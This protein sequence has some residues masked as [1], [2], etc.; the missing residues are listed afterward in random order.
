MA[1]NTCITRL[2]KLSSCPSCGKKTVGASWRVNRSGGGGGGGGD[3]DSGGGGDDSPPRSYSPIVYEAEVDD[4]GD[5]SIYEE[6]DIEKM[7]KQHPGKIKAIRPGIGKDWDADFLGL[8]N[9]SLKAKPD[10]LKSVVK[11]RVYKEEGL[12]NLS[13][14]FARMV[15]CLTGIKQLDI[16]M[17]REF[18]TPEVIRAIVCL[19]ALEELDNGFSS[20]NDEEALMWADAFAKAPMTKLKKFEVC[21]YHDSEMTVKG[22]AATLNSLAGKVRDLTVD[23][24]KD[25]YAGNA[26]PAIAAL[27]KCLPPL[28]RLTVRISEKVASHA[29][30]PL[31]ASLPSCTALKFFDLRCYE[32]ELL[33]PQISMILSAI[34]ACTSLEELLLASTR[35]FSA[36]DFLRLLKI[37]LCHPKLHTFNSGMTFHA[38]DDSQYWWRAVKVARQ[39]AKKKGWKKMERIDEIWIRLDDRERSKLGMEDPSYSITDVE[40]DEDESAIE[41]FEDDEPAAVPAP[42]RA[43]AS[44]A[45]VAGRAPPGR[46]P[47]GVV[48][49]ARGSPAPATGRVA[50]GRVAPVMQPAQR[51]LPAPAG[52]AVLA[53]APGRA[54]VTSAPVARAVPTLAPPSGGGR[55][56][57]AA[58]RAAVPVA[59][60]VPATVGEVGPEWKLKDKK[61]IKAVADDFESAIASLKSKLGDE[62]SMVVDWT[63]FGKSTAG[64]DDREPGENVITRVVCAFVSDDVGQFDDDVVEAL[65]SLV[66]SRVVTFTCVKDHN[67]GGRC[68]VKAAASG[69]TITWSADYWG[70]SYNDAMLRDWVL[71][72]C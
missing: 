4:D 20:M 66:T 14:E 59:T 28:T 19:P 34:K 46:A 55:A 32:P 35:E 42:A 33:V 12:F 13:S 65:N 36:D 1:N 27:Y 37:V 50:P 62:W 64:K 43:L 57:I 10:L 17:D 2:K 54:V 18:M 25:P 29:F 3:S 30:A 31:F 71:N 15:T 49:P 47:A 67:E 56:A 7:A 26:A 40:A 9:K 48:A 60:P 23:L 44:V 52:R 70:Y 45:G 61:S 41:A 39:L 24:D 21:T 11:M 5:C 8:V 58:A 16:T 51:A 53:P 63:A 69:V 38:R 6:G 68:K 72:N 22:I